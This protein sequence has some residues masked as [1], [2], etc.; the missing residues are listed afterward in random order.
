MLTK[1]GAARDGQ[2]AMPAA[3]RAGTSSAVV[4]KGCTFGACAHGALAVITQPSLRGSRTGSGGPKYCRSCV[5][6][7]SDRLGHARW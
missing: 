3:G 1:F 2:A 5:R 4:V 7:S 6:L